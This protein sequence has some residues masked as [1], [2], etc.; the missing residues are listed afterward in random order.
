LVTIIASK[1]LKK[2]TVKQQSEKRK[3]Y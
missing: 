3:M 1:I 2:T